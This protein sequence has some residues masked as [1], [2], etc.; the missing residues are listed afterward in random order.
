M[1]RGGR[2]TFYASGQPAGARADR[3][4]YQARL[5]LDDQARL[6]VVR[7]MYRRR[8]GEDAPSRR[9][10]GQLRGIEGVR[11]RE[12]YRLMALKYGIDWSRRN[13]DHSRWDAA[14]IPNRCPSSAT[15][16]LY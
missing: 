5:V 1:G 8:F 15:A 14:D 11:V 10:I 3:L 13:Y 6:N 9:S 16:C 7:E 12:L 4:L 2:R